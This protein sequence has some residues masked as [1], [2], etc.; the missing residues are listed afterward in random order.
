LA[1][2]LPIWLLEFILPA[3]CE[4]E[5]PMTLSMNF[6]LC[7]LCVASLWNGYATAEFHTS[8]NSKSVSGSN[9]I[10]IIG[11]Y[12]NSGNAPDSI[13]TIANIDPNYNVIIITFANFFNKTLVLQIQGPYDQDREGLA[14]DI[15]SWKQG[16]DMYGRTRRA[17]L[18]IGG[19]NG[20]WPEHLS[21]DLIQAE[22]DAMLAQYHLDGLDIDLEGRSVLEASTLIP[23]VD[24]LISQ[25]K[26]V[27]AAP[28]PAWG[29]MDSYLG[30]MRHLTYVHPQF[31]NNGP[32]SVGGQW[33][34]PNN[35]WPTPWTV[36]DWQAESQGESF[37][38]GVV[39]SAVRAA[40][41]DSATGGGM[42]IPATPDAASFYN[43]WDI[44][45]LKTQVERSG[46]KHVG[47]W[48]IAYDNT[49]G[50][51]FAKTIGELNAKLLADFHV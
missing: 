48:A 51:K 28:E 45:L 11:Y 21:Q 8:S 27:S 31:Y 26:V 20:V 36:S 4:L 3:H 24:N 47:T 39:E 29:V 6:L 33:L 44:D 16:T 10:N 2:A 17:L 23:V 35:L 38:A 9:M 30:V 37:W 15:L 14:R 19:A 32:N 40:G 5:S 46:V 43:H 12:G 13:P 25:G 42:L 50:W 22:L 7:G 18:S 34:P 1:Q 41:M 49:Q